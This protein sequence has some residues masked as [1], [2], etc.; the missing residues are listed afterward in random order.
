MAD[1]PQEYV[2]MMESDEIKF[3][4]NGDRAVVEYNFFKNCLADA[5]VL[6][7]GDV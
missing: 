2:T 5:L 7:R 1:T 6:S 3:T 4:N